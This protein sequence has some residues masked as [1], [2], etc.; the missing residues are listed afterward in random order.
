MLGVC[1]MIPPEPQSG[2]HVPYFFFIF[3]WLPRCFV[4]NVP[5]AFSRFMCSNPC[6]QIFYY[7]Q[8]QF[9]RSHTSLLI[10]LHTLDIWIKKVKRKCLNVSKSKEKSVTMLHAL[11]RARAHTRNPFSLSPCRVVPREYINDDRWRKL[12]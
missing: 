3:L 11:C 8:S 1:E 10:N 4:L 2:D 5:P 12:K 9:N 7:V 6:S